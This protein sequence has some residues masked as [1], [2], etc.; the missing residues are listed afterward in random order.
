MTERSAR[1]S[2]PTENPTILQDRTV[3]RSTIP[4]SLA[5]RRAYT[6][7]PR[8]TPSRAQRA[9]DIE[10][11]IFISGAIG[12]RRQ[13]AACRQ[14]G[15]GGFRRSTFSSA[16]RLFGGDARTA[17]ARARQASEIDPRNADAHRILGDAALLAGQ[18]A[19]AEREFTASIVLEPN[20]ARAEYGMGVVAERQKKWNTAA[21]HYRRA[22][23]LAPKNTSAAPASGRT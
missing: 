9:A 5:S 18:D 22:L 8:R 1:G 6:V 7:S 19:E 23:T 2:S 17:G 15:S 16:E 12:G 21:S 10:R 3:R 11:G 13:G 20:N 14:R 4:K